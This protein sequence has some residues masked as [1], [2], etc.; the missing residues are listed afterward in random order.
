MTRSQ[1]LAFAD[2]AGGVAAASALLDDI[3]EV[4]SGTGDP[5]FDT[6]SD[7]YRKQATKLRTL[8]HSEVTP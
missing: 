6:L 3:A 8:S 7:I 2:H 5:F 1:L 4:Y